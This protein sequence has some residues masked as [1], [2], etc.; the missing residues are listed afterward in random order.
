MVGDV[1]HLFNVFRFIPMTLLAYLIL[2]PVAF[3]FSDYASVGY[4]S[5]VILKGKVSQANYSYNETL[6]FEWIVLTVIAIPSGVKL[7]TSE[8]RNILTMPFIEGAKIIGGSKLHIFWRHVCPHLWPRLLPIYVR[9]VIQVLL[10]MMHLGLF[11][12]FIGGTDIKLDPSNMD[13]LSKSNEWAGLI[14]HYLDQLGIHSWI[15]LAPVVMFMLTILSLNCIVE[16]M[17]RTMMQPDFIRHKANKPEK[18]NKSGKS[19]VSF[20]RIRDFG[21]V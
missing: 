14:G 16:G 6:I 17:N 2:Q 20:E 9:E 7:M 19:D 18:Q 21:K 15:P 4:L 3:N 10:V 13:Y 5:D 1:G 11:K 12:L 8:L